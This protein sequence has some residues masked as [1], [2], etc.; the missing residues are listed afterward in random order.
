[1]QNEVFIDYQQILPNL[2]LIHPEKAVSSVCLAKREDALGIELVQMKS[3]FSSASLSTWQG[4]GVPQ[5]S[6][7]IIKLFL[8]SHQPFYSR[9]E[10]S[11]VSRMP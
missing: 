1:M 6:S 8:A 4:S 7:S 10:L 11:L 3:L 9:D 2:P 5:H